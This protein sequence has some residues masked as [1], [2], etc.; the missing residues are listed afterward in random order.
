MIYQTRPTRSGRGSWPRIPAHF[1]KIIPHIE[2]LVSSL[3]QKAFS[4]LNTASRAKNLANSASW[5][6][7]NPVSRSKNVAFFGVPHCISIKSRIPK[8]PFQTLGQRLPGSHILDLCGNRFALFIPGIM[9]YSF[10]EVKEGLP[11]ECFLRLL[12]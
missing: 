4:F 2:L 11:K 10:I 5:K 1:L 12:N 8:I 7:S 6:W 3:F 9:F